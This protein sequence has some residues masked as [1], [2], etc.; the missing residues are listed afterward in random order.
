MTRMPFQLL[1]DPRILKEDVLDAEQAEIE[2][3][4]RREEAE[5]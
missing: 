1:P 5:E 2:E 4:E 3:A